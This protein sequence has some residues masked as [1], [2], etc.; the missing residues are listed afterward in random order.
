M[1]LKTPPHG[2]R[3]PLTNRPLAIAP[4]A[5]D[6][7]MTVPTALFDAETSTTRRDPGWDLVEG[8]IAVLP[9]LGPLMQRGDEFTRWLGIATY[10]DIA[11]A[12]SEAFANP[13]VSGVLLEIDS[14]GGEV[15]GLFD[16]VDHLA[17]L[18]TTSKKPL[19][20]VAREQA[21]SAAYAIATVCDRIYVTQTG[22]VGSV[23]VLAVHLDITARDETEGTKYALIH[24]GAKKTDGNPHIPLSDRAA[25]DI[26][27]DVNDLYAK[28]TTRVARHRRMSREAVIATEA[29]IYR[30]QHA[31]EAGLADR[32]GTIEAAIGDFAAMLDAPGFQPS[33]TRPQNPLSP[34]AERNTSMTTNAKPGAKPTVTA[35]PPANPQGTA[36]EPAT[37]LATAEPAPVVAPTA[38]PVPAAPV[39][40]AAVQTA[41]EA[42]AQLADTIRAEAAEIAGIA[43][44]A[45]KL[46]LTIDT[47]EAVRAGTNPDA[48]RQTVL[49]QLAKQSAASAIVP[50]LP[51]PVDNLSPTESPIVQAAKEAAGIN[52]A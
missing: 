4:R 27:A 24:V 22:E 36:N 51:A 45:A 14:P 26:Q 44:Q 5:V 50:A 15:A 39:P 52:P 8:G 16:L 12:A 10:D 32:I 46:G 25:S 38:Q 49:E 43:A 2:T 6:A 31:L 3:F 20:S 1:T 48:L 30:G 7:M 41:P 9:V 33:Q 17:A 28:F 29:A 19:W 21:L 13:G 34:S 23:G 18:K 47:A 42:G 40:V 11:D 37:P 35:D